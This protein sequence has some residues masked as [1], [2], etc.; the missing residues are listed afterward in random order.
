M[1]VMIHIQPVD[2]RTPD[3]HLVLL[4]T[5]SHSHLWPDHPRH[6]LR[7]SDH[8][9]DRMLTQ[10]QRNQSKNSSNTES[11][12]HLTPD[13]TVGLTTQMVYQ[14]IQSK[15]FSLK[16]EQSAENS[17]VSEHGTHVWPQALIFISGMFELLCLHA[18]VIS[19]SL[20][21]NCTWHT[22]HTHFI[23]S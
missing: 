12:V 1:H 17:L 22:H 21:L 18:L 9:T 15:E 5:V 13:H 2:G 20:C 11:H 6:M 14:Y 23:W 3:F 19:W 10:A 16:E 4:W 7:G 8:L